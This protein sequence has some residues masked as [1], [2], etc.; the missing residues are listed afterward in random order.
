[1]TSPLLLEIYRAKITLTPLLLSDKNQASLTPWVNTHG[2][3]VMLPQPCQTMKIALVG[4]EVC[5]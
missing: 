1:M 3:Q 5:V 2:E 4:S